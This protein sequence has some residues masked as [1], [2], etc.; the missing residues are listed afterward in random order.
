MNAGKFAYLLTD[1]IFG[2]IAI[3]LIWHRHWR[4]LKKHWQ[5]ILDIAIFS[6]PFAYFD[7]FAVRWGAWQFDP[8][9]NL[10]SL[11]FGEYVE[12]FLFVALIFVAIASYT[13][14]HAKVYGYK[15]VAPS[16]NSHSRTRRRKLSPASRKSRS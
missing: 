2:G 13:I 15:K 11:I 1:I 6:L 5:F 12:G 8:E 4:F 14:A 3:F 7:L 10:G 16:R 9:R